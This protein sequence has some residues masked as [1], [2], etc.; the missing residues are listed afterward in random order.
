VKTGPEDFEDLFNLYVRAEV[1]PGVP[2]SEGLTRQKEFRA[3]LEQ[4]WNAS[5][6]APFP[7]TYHAAIVSADPA[8]FLNKL[9]H[10]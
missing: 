10:D 8:E 9:V 5:Q 7:L 2:P 6:P 3:R 1:E 4:I